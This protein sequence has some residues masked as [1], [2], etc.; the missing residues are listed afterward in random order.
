[1]FKELDID[2]PLLSWEYHNIIEKL[3]NVIFNSGAKEDLKKHNMDKH[4]AHWKPDF[5]SK[6]T[7]FYDKINNLVFKYKYLGIRELDITRF[8]P[9]GGLCWHSDKTD[10]A[11]L[12]PITPT[13]RVTIEYDNG[14]TYTRTNKPVIIDTIT[15]HRTIPS[16]RLITT[17]RIGITTCM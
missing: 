5:F 13:T 12:L 4:I 7:K 11:L 1:M 6:Y 14:K 9:G 3:D 15:K 17:F 8:K 16:D 2:N 10:F